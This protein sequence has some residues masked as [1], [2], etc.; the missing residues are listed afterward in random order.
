MA[1]RKNDN[2]VNVE[3]KVGILRTIAKQIYSDP[4]IKIREAVANSMDNAAS[5]F[6]MY[7]H[8]PSRSI[9][10]FDNGTGISSE[11]VVKIFKTIGYGIQKTDKFSNSYFG[12]GLMSILELGKSAI[13]LSKATGTDKILKL[14]IDTEKIYSTDMEDKPIK[15]INTCF[16][17]S[18]ISFSDRETYS[19]IDTDQIQKRFNDTF[20]QTYT[21]I[22]LQDIEASIFSTII[23]D[24]FKTGLSQILPLQIDPFDPFFNYIK[25]DGLF[26]KWITNLFDSERRQYCPTIDFYIGVHDEKE[27]IHLKKYFPK[28]QENLEISKADILFGEKKYNL[29]SVEHSYAYYYICSTED[30]ENRKTGQGSDENDS[31]QN[32]DSKETGFWVRNRNF[33]VK[34]N[35]YFKRPGSTKKI[36]DQ[37]LQKWLFGEIFHTN[38]TDFLIVTRDEYSWEAK[39]FTEFYNSLYDLLS[40]LNNKLR[41]AWKTSKIVTDN[42]ITPFTNVGSKND[43]FQ[44]TQRMLENAGIL[45]PG[46]MLSEDITTVFQKLNST[47]NTD[48]EDESKT[49]NNLLLQSKGEILLLDDKDVKVYI[50]STVS[51]DKQFIKQR[52]E[53]SNTITVRISPE[54][55]CDKEVTFLGKKFTVY[56]VAGIDNDSGISVNSDEK[57][58]FI[59][60]FN[61]ELLKYSITMIDVYIA[62]E[63]AYSLSKS[64][65]EMKDIFLSIVGTKLNKFTDGKKDNIFTAL[66]EE[67]SRRI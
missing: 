15:S 61:H 28:F 14:D 2:A 54:I 31:P 5:S 65:E 4:V 35:D 47:R 7:A 58:I 29:D 3:T 60:P 19:Y 66:Q 25:D 67:L 27:I 53:S 43:P 21:E 32:D 22:I 57:K 40:D 41:T 6:I 16:R 48:I 52:E 24:E 33:L 26:K 9:C 1:N 17:I 36:I 18:N 55:F 45:R 37:P 8:R 38:M 23:S 34:R 59:N 12:L 20:P 10:L 13:I 62:I 50:D 39:G 51:R 42:I 30:I 63:I 64:L 56:F 11:K 44:R 46:N 49:I